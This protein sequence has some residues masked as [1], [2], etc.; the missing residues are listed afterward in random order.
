MV[1]YRKQPGLNHNW[2]YAT[3]FVWNWRLWHRLMISVILKYYHKYATNLF[4]DVKC[5][6]IQLLS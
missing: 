6:F 4:V 3:G 2:R 5:R 1:A